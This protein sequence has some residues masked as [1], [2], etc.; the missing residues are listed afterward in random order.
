MGSRPRALALVR[1]G[2]EEL[3]RS[4][5][6]LPEARGDPGAL[7]SLTDLEQQIL[8]AWRAAPEFSPGEL[9]P[10]PGRRPAVLALALD[11]G[12]RRLA[13]GRVKGEVQILGLDPSAPGQ[14]L[15]E[16]QAHRKACS[17]V[18][19]T[20]GDGELL[21]GGG[22]QVVRR[23]DLT[24]RRALRRMEGPASRAVGVAESCGVLEASWRGYR[25]RGPREQ[26]EG[27]ESS[28]GFTPFPG[29]LL[30]G[31]GEEERERLEERLFAF[32]QDLRPELRG[33]R[34]EG[35]RTW[36]RASYESCEDPE[37]ALGTA[38]SG[39]ALGMVLPGVA[40]SFD[41]RGKLLR[42]VRDPELGVP[43]GFAQNQAPA[44]AVGP[45]GRTLLLGSR[46]RARGAT[47][48]LMDEGSLHPLLP[49]HAI[50]AVA[51]SPSGDLA[52]L[53]TQ[54]GRLFTLPVGARG[55]QRSPSP[56]PRQEALPEPL[57][58][59]R[60]L[61]EAPRQP[62]A[63]RS[64]PDPEGFQLLATLTPRVG[65]ILPGFLRLGAR[66]LWLYPA[67]NPDP[68]T[69]EVAFQ[70]V[71]RYDLESRDFLD[72]PFGLDQDGGPGSFEVRTRWWILSETEWRPA[73]P[74]TDSPGLPP[75]PL[76][77]GEVSIRKQVQEVIGA[78]PRSWVRALDVPLYACQVVKRPREFWLVRAE[79][80]ARPRRFQ[81]R[82]RVLKLALSPG[83]TRLAMLTRKGA[84][85]LWGLP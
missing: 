24:E 49:E 34:I 6:V 81:T 62:G 17:A 51:L 29:I 69:P 40:A 78:P 9:A 64:A 63:R 73:P 26:P 47:L 61:S 1:Q 2:L 31:I 80:P 19:F 65:P 10:S 22:D 3:A 23:W 32:L 39:D 60:D 12:E 55:L 84:V 85:E 42:V 30:P 25:I 28:G 18:A 71:G 52:V 67:R 82:D 77:P 14:L 68:R 33:R 21:T 45:G 15:W 5:E 54:R 16:V 8:G 66:D 56:D 57:P 37:L 7:G 41:P 72:Y 27:A 70:R 46:P 79:D 44:L 38:A 50:T 36:S 53:G 20:P 35:L 43:R 48:V 76:A 59:D 75:E 13:V 58:G 4:G 11:D 74:G 83:G